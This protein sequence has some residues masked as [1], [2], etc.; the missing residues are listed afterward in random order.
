MLKAIDWKLNMPSSLRFAGSSAMPSFCASRGE[1]GA[2]RLP[3]SRISPLV[4]R[5]MP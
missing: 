5:S 1:R 4:A 3:S 2:I